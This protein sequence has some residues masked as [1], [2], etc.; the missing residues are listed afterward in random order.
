[1]GK[2][3][4]NWTEYTWNPV[5]GCSPVSAGCEHC[6]A[7]RMAKRLQAMG[8]RKYEHGFEVKCHVDALDEPLKW[9]KSKRIFVCSMGDLFHGSINP[10]F[11]INVFRRMAIIAPQHIYQVLTKRPTYVLQLNELLR[12]TPNIWMGVTV[13]DESCLWRLDYLRKTGAAVKFLSCEPLLGPLHDLDL[14]GIDWVIVGGE[15]GPGA[16]R[17]DGEW[18]TEIIDKCI[19]SKVPFFFKGWGTYNGR[20]WRHYRCIYDREWNEMPRGYDAN[21][22]A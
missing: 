4:I 12:W 5:T 13:E 14:T 7:A 9:K 21:E 11:V 10:S 16:R 15:T 2:S 1:M 8:V 6:Y 20:D 18:V 17:M 19:E 3:R 22:S